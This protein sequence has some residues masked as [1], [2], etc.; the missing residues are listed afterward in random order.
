MM[1]GAECWSD[2]R[3]VRAR[4]QVRVDQCQKGRKKQTRN[5]KP[6]VQMLHLEEVQ[7]AFDGRLIELVDQSWQSCTSL[8]D[9]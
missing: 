9:K 5:M 2:H 8:Q 1:R 7:V 6:K 4:V 3:M